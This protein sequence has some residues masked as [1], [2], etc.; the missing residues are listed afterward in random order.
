M[1]KDA[2][3]TEKVSNKEVLKQGRVLEETLKNFGVNAKVSK[4]RIGPAVTQFEIQPDIGVKISKIINLQN[5][6][7]LSLAA[8]DIRIDA[9]IP[10][11]SAVGN[12]VPNA[13]ISMVSLR[14]VLKRKNSGNLLEVELGKDMSGSPISAEINKMPHLLVAGATGSGQ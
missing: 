10:G 3:V 8:K 12:E 9:P 13:V 7:A 2:E 11:K 4:I 5:D 14:E 6:I 1:L